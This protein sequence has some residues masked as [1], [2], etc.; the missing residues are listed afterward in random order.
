M[1]HYL[2]CISFILSAFASSL[3]PAAMIPTSELQQRTKNVVDI[4][5]LETLLLQTDVQ[6]QLVSFGVDPLLAKDRISQLTP[7]ELSQLNQK[8][9]ELPAGSGIIGTM[10]LIFVVLV[11]TDALGA[12]DVF[13][14]VDPIN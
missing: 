3:A 13:E 2:V 7:L 11:I 12:T 14:F 8:I 9:N 10:V 1:S 5:Q 6:E 4:Q